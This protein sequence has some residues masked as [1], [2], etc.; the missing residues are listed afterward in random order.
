MAR[1]ASFARGAR[2]PAGPTQEGQPCSHSPAELSSRDFC[3]RRLCVRKRGSEKP[4]PPGKASKRE[5]VGWQNCL[6]LGERAKHPAWALAHGEGER[7]K[8]R[9]FERDPVRGG[10]HFVF[11]ELEFAVAD[12]FVGEEFDFLE[13][14]DLGADE[15]IAVGERGS[16]GS[17][18]SRG[19]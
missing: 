6:A 15:D 17:Y 12:I 4:M 2:S 18:G 5:R 14:H 19:S 9:A 10:V 1:A 8:Q 16:R 11:G 3:T 13:A 7:F